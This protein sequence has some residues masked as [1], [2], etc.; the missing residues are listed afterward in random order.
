MDLSIKPAEEIVVKKT[1]EELKH[2][3]VSTSEQTTNPD[4]QKA[5]STQASYDTSDI[6]DAPAKKTMEKIQKQR[7]KLN[8]QKAR[9][10]LREERQKVKEQRE[11]LK[12]QRARVK[13]MSEKNKKPRKKVESKPKPKLQTKPVKSRSTKKVKYV[14]VSES[15]S[16]ESSEEIVYVKKRKNKK[17]PKRVTKTSTNRINDL[18]Q[19]DITKLYGVFKK[20]DELNT[21]TQSNKKINFVNPVIPNAFTHL[22]N[23]FNF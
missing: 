16:D 14:E 21:K 1:E 18:T 20:A 6:F 4:E 17:K 10:V 2:E 9:L 5:K 12:Q 7:D 19:E 13:E 8:K 23:P 22:N 11:A 15:S 3:I